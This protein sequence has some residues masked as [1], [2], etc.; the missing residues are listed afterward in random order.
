MQR[1]IH[2]NPINRVSRTTNSSNPT[3]TIKINK[4][5]ATRNHPT[6]GPAQDKNRILNPVPV[7][8]NRAMRNPRTRNQRTPNPGNRA[9]Q[10]QARAKRM[11]SRPKKA[12][13]IPLIPPRRKMQM[14]QRIIRTMSNP[15]PGI[16]QPMPIHKTSRDNNPKPM[17]AR[18]TPTNRQRPILIR[19]AMVPNRNP[20]IPMLIVHREVLTA[21]HPAN[22]LASQ[23][24][25]G[26]RI[27]TNQRMDPMIRRTMLGHKMERSDR[28]TV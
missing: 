5:L 18:K 8:P 23:I 17:A 14:P 4:S 3:P 6:T 13:A 11:L 25:I 24:R 28:T 27:L 15:K 2:N 16:N 21:R 19:R 10:N 26:I 1:E 9:R 7:N 12:A 20:Q 22:N